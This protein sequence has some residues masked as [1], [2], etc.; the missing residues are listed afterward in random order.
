MPAPTDCIDTLREMAADCVGDHPGWE[1]EVKPA[2]QHLWPE[3]SEESRLIVVIFACRLMFE[4][5]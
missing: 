1:L 5:N 3:L 2:I 4:T